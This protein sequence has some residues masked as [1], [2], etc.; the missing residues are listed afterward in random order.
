MVDSSNVFHAISHPMRRAILE[1]LADGEQPAMQ[2][3]AGFDVTPGA[4]SQHLKI[5][6]EHG[7]VTRRREGRK[8]IYQL[9]PAPLREVFDWVRRYERFWSDRLDALGAYLEKTHDQGD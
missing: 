2:L 1:E 8:R 7:L 6:L 5:L 4:L 9:D 3:A